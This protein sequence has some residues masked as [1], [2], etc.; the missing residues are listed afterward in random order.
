MSGRPGVGK[1][2]LLQRLTDCIDNYSG[3]LTVEVRENRKRIG[4]DI[5][6]LPVRE[7]ISFARICGS[8]V[9]GKYCVDGKALKYVITRV[10]INKFLFIDEIGPMEVR[11][12]F[13]VQFLESIKGN[14]VATVHR[15]LA[16]YWKKKLG[17]DLVWL[18]PDNR[19]E[20]FQRLC[21]MMS[22]HRTER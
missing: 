14:F 8:P 15:N 21:R 6:V 13:F 18:T 2:T 7:R 17:A 20:I 5:V 9:V 3:F 4:F 1:T 10:D 22:L 19:D 12:P 11:F 16:N